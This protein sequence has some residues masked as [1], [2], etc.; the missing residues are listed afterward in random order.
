MKSNLWVIIMAGGSGERLW[1]L[2]RR[3]KPKQTLKLGYK[4]SLVQATAQRLKKLVPARRMVVVTTRP[5]AAVI[6]Q[7][8]PEIPANHFLVEPFARNT[9]AAI[10]L[11]TAVILRE[12]PDAVILVLPADHLIRPDAKFHAVVRKTVAVAVQEK[13]LVCLGITPT[14]PATGYGYIE[15]K[16]SKVSPGAYRVKRFIEKPELRRARQLIKKRGMA[17]NGGIFCWKGRVV[18]N[19]I[20]KQ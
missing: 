3:N 20:K 11:G 16:G 7:Q 12:D 1:P 5:Q 13:G 15:P 8:L 6:R 17:W 14:Y 18:M 9:A 4:Q 10:G 2:S 19:E